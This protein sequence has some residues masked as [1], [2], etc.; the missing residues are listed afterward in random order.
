M[1]KQIPSPVYPPILL[2]SILMAYIPTFFEDPSLLHNLFS[3]IQTHDQ[4]GVY[5]ENLMK[6]VMSFKIK[7]S[8]TSINMNY[9]PRPRFNLLIKYF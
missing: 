9:S 4:I 5:R 3:L 1:Y 8:P 7:D 6:P 2:P